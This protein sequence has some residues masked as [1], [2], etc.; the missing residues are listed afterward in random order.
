MLSSQDRTERARI[1]A[2]RRHR[3]DHPD[4]IARQQDY[5][6]SRLADYIVRTVSS[7]PPLTQEQR[8]RLALLLRAGG[9][10]A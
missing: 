8:D 6:A 10:A 1:A 4:V 9:D 3:G 7:A 5:K 2:L